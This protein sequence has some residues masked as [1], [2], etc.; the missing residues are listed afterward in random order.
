MLP[1][2]YKGLAGMKCLIL[3]LYIWLDVAVSAFKV[4]KHSMTTLMITPVKP[5]KVQFKWDKKV[6]SQQ[7]TKRYSI[8]VHV[9]IGRLSG[10]FTI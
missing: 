8:A 2:T 1:L 3:L 9:K 5:F 7:S 6:G 10:R 4:C